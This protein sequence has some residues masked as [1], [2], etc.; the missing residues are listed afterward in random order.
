MSSAVRRL[1]G[2]VR[3]LLR[4]RVLPLRVA[5]FQWRARRE[6]RRA[7]DRWSLASVTRPGD[8]GILLKLARGRRRVV[9]LG[10]GTG[11]TA[12]SLAIADSKREVVTYDPVDRP[13]ARERYM[14]LAGERVRS[15]ITYV[16]EPGATGPRDDQSVDLLFIDSTHE[17]QGTIDELNAWQA[18]LQPGALIVLKD[19]DHPELP[20]VREAV[21]QADLNGRQQGT[22]F[23]HTVESADG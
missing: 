12:L 19:F 22:L 15:R 2:D 4:L 18:V 14:A 17:P 9:E 13:R 1:R 10:T 6:A 5:R 8:L 16:R 21:R 11:W 20:G 3:Y 7:G 23:V